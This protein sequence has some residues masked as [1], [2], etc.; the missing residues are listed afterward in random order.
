[1][2]NHL[3]LLK[4][5]NMKAKMYNDS[6][7]F[8]D[9]IIIYSSLKVE[10]VDTKDYPDFCDCWVGSGEWSDGT[11]LTESELEELEEVYPGLAYELAMESIY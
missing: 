6:L 2:G 9:G 11:P 3:G 10:G 8:K 1:V 7:P 4:Y 5:K